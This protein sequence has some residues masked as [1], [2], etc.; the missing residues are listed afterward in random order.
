MVKTK[1]FQAAIEQ[2]K[3][4]ND[5][6]TL[7]SSPDSVPS[8]PVL[9]P[10]MPPK[11]P[12]CNIPDDLDLENVYNPKYTVVQLISTR[13]K[14][15]K[16][17][18]PPRPPN[19]FFLFKNC[20]ML[21]LRKLG[22]RY[23]MPDVCRQSKILWN[24]ISPEV[25]EKYDILALQAQILH[26][27]MYP[28]YKFSPKK[29]QIF[30]PHVFPSETT[31]VDS[32]MLNTFSVT[33]F[34]GA[35]DDSKTESIASSESSPIISSPEITSSPVPSVFSSNDSN[36]SVAESELMIPQQQ[37][38]VDYNYNNLLYYLD[39]INSISPINEVIIPS[40]PA[41]PSHEINDIYSGIISP[42]HPLTPITPITP[43]EYLY[44]DNFQLC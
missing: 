37:N 42:V 20:Y 26:Q 30:K 11:R 16:Q 29:R 7:N 33:N 24:N 22:Y 14:P 21:E 5:I 41:V 18:A 34:L 31:I 19:S 12:K 35:S 2:L 38:M 23:C 8:S 15:R 10:A 44:Q 27:E 40:S 43:L 4:Q 3:K 39:S 36:E 32:S 28:G 25:K 6:A 13:R 1:A 17:L 9:S